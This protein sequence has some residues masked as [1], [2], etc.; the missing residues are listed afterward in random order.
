MV[1]SVA[2]KDIYVAAAGYNPWKSLPIIIDVGTNNEKLINDKYYVGLNQKRA[3]DEEFFELLD[4]FMAV[5]KYKYPHGIY[6][7]EDIKAQRGLKIIEKYS[8]TFNIL[9]EDL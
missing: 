5:S 6:V 9:N 1:I 8:K 7:F 3:S 2:R 4:E